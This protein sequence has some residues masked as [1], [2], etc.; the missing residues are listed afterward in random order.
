MIN[1]QC[2][3]GAITYEVAGDMLWAAHCHCEDC[4]RAAGADYVSWF[5]VRREDVT[6]RGARGFHKS[7]PKVTRSFCPT[8]GTPMSFETDVLPEE[9]HLYARSLSDR[10]LYQP[11]AHIFWSEKV[12]WLSMD[13]GLPKHEKGLQAATLDGKTIF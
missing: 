2:M 4:Q 12:P 3:C 8:C 11:T 1:G 5:G 6:W 9:T 7:S 10:S 13:D